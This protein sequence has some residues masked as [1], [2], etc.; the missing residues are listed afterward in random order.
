MLI[1]T[2]A[3]QRFCALIENIMI[4]SWVIKLIYVFYGY[5]YLFFLLTT[6]DFFEGGRSSNTSSTGP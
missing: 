2:Y 5:I 1:F 3:G 6:C 4:Y